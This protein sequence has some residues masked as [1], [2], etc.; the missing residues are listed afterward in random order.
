MRV[1]CET[2]EN[3][4]WNWWRWDDTGEGEMWYWWRWDM[5][6]VR[7]RCG[8]G[9][10]GMWYWWGWDVILVRVRCG[11]GECGMWYW[12]GGNVILMI[13]SIELMIYILVMFQ[14]VWFWPMCFSIRKISDVKTNGQVFKLLIFLNIHV[15]FFAWDLYVFFNYGHH[16]YHEN[17]A[18]L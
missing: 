12:W 2:N 5:I 8:T 14:S 11:T 1:R 7:V 18:R 4:M 15:S 9:E 16:L 6:L 10:G 17:W 13:L 3:E